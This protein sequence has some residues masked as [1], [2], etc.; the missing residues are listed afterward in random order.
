MRTACAMVSLPAIRTSDIA[1]SSAP[2]PNPVP[3]TPSERAAAVAAASRQAESDVSIAWPA[4]VSPESPV[5]G[6]AGTGRSGHGVTASPPLF[7]VNDPL[8]AKGV[9]ANASGVLVNGV[10][11][12]F[13]AASP[14]AAAKAPSGWQPD[15]SATSTASTVRV[16][17][18]RPANRAVTGVCCAACARLPTSLPFESARSLPIHYPA[19]LCRSG[20]VYDTP[21]HPSS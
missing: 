4:A 9:A 2:V 11:D 10:N 17:R 5:A 3:S 7:A 20:A 18:R 15:A 1:I 16:S 19:R 14:A 21:A 13:A 8:A 12:D 6:N